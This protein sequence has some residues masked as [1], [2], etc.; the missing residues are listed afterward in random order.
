MLPPSHDEKRGEGV[1]VTILRERFQQEQNAITFAEV[2]WLLLRAKR[3]SPFY[4]FMLLAVTCGIRCD[5]L[6]TLTLF[7]IRGFRAIQ[8]SVD[9]EKVDEE[10]GDVVMY[11]KHRCVTLDPW[12]AQ[13]LQAYYDLHFL[14]IPTRDGYTYFSPHADMKP[15]KNGQQLSQKLFPWRNTKV[16]EA[17]WWK[18]RQAL[19]RAGFDA[20]RMESLTTWHLRQKVKPTYVVRFH[21]LRHLALSR[22]VWLTGGDL[23]RG[24]S[25][26]GHTRLQ[27]TERYFHSPEQMG[28]TK[29]ELL[30]PWSSLLGF[31]PG[32]VSLTQAVRPEQTILNMF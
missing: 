15:N 27:T 14:K 16:V 17:L 5:E 2:R 3:H 4:T 26:I 22:Y 10:S 20:H 1:Q 18:Y 30:Q 24:S 13:E 8:Y 23:K 28:V 29:E 25:W 32:Q 11:R 21:G 31:V 12:V 9:K 6:L 19:G 7:N